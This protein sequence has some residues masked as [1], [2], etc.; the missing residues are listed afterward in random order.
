M[1]SL[2]A[3]TTAYRLNKYNIVK[4]DIFGTHATAEM[5]CSSSVA[6]ASKGNR[7]NQNSMVTD[8]QKSI[9]TKNWKVLSS[10]LSGRGGKVFL[11]IFEMSPRVK[12]LFPCRDKVGDELL[13]DSHFKG[14][15]SRFMQAVGA[16]IENID[17]CDETLT[18]LLLGLGRQHVHYKGF[19][20]DYWNS[21]EIAMMEVWKE[22][23]GS[24]FKSENQDAWHIIFKFILDKL[25]QGYEIALKEEKQRIPRGRNAQALAKLV[26][27]TSTSTAHNGDSGHVMAAVEIN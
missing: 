12:N 2:A 7:S 25:N 22:D 8:S 21:F 5:G 17:N 10:D 15:A 23:L 13:K 26:P 16:V 1:C 27:D 24:K 4:S 9:I 19:Q 11:R 14:H 6:F 18:P 20:P 3:E